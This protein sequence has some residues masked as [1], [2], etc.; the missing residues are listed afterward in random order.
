MPHQVITLFSLSD[1]IGSIINSSS[2]PLNRPLLDIGHSQR[3]S[4]NSFF[5]LII[6]KKVE[7]YKFKKRTKFRQIVQK[8]LFRNINSRS[9][10]YKIKM[11]FRTEN[12]PF[13]NEIRCVFLTPTKGDRGY[14]GCYK[15]LLPQGYNRG[16][17]V[18]NAGVTF[19]G[20]KCYR[21][22]KGT[23]YRSAKISWNF[24]SGASLYEGSFRM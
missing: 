17:G 16:R 3:A 7:D 23:R 4:Q 21:P 20:R 24:A 22:Y 9:S 13:L 10:P 14:M 1:F 12:V 6:I 2:S 8:L 19:K 5:D 18:S 15:K 11:R